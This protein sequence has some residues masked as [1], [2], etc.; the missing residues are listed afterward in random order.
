MEDS[1]DRSSRTQATNEVGALP[2]VLMNIATH[3]GR[4]QPCRIIYSAGAEMTLTANSSV[5]GELSFT[6]TNL[7]D[8]LIKLR[9]HLEKIGYFLLC[10]AARKDTYPSRAIKQM[11]GGFKVYV[12]RSGQQASPADL[13]DAL[14]PANLDQIATVDEQRASYERW[15]RSLR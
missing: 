2:E 12:L 4:A 1:L 13:V 6:G 9:L 3:D 10:N 5:F 11:G 8:A 7:F 15:L 14:G